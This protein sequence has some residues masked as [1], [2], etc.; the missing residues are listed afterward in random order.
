MP[1]TPMAAE[2]VTITGYNGDEIEAYF[3]RPTT[4][5]PH[6]GAVVI[7]HMPGYDRSTKEI[8]RTFARD[9]EELRPV[10]RVACHVGLRR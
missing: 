10:G 9:V 5:G 7:H 3:A 1:D 8:T 2:S 4:A 6:P